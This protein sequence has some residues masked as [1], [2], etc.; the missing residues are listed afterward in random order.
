ME[1]NT[2]LLQISFTRLLGKFDQSFIREIVRQSGWEIKILTPA[3]WRPASGQQIVLEKEFDPEYEILT[4]DCRF[5]GNR[6]FAYYPH[7]LKWLLQIYQPHLIHFLDNPFPLT[8]RLLFY[9]RNT[10]LPDSHLILQSSSFPLEKGLSMLPFKKGDGIFFPGIIKD[11]PPPAALKKTLLHYSPPAVNTRAFHP[12]N[13]PELLEKISPSGRPVIGIIES[14][15]S[16]RVL[17]RALL[18]VRN[19]PAQL[20]VIGGRQPFSFSANSNILQMEAATQQELAQFFNCM[21]IFLL[22]ESGKGLE[23]GL[24]A[25]SSGIPVVYGHSPFMEAHFGEGGQSFA[26]GDL[27]DLRRTLTLLLENEDRRRVMGWRGRRYVRQNYSLSTAAQNILE[28]YRALLNIR[29]Q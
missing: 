20:L 19:I 8:R 25:L 7:Y 5:N 13:L 24:Q 16:R 28:G 9:Y 3:V 21:D 2:R 15:Q 26:A 10:F 11:N 6:Y 1:E 27:Q 14:E 29:V 4:E 23:A 18:A 17:Q 22:P 12:R